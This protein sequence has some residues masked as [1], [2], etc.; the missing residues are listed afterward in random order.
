MRKGPL[1]PVVQAANVIKITASCGRF[2]ILLLCSSRASFLLD[3]RFVLVFFH[4]ISPAWDAHCLQQFFLGGYVSFIFDIG[5]RI[6]S[7]LPESIFIS[8]L[9]RTEGLKD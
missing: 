3:I 1:G 8:P 6:L 9:Q 5:R 4:G 7:A 2:N